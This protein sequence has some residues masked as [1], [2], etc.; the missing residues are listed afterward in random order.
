ML[1]IFKIGMFVLNQE[2]TIWIIA[3]LEKPSLPSPLS[4]VL[5]MGFKVITDAVAFRIFV[6][7][8]ERG[9]YKQ[10]STWHCLEDWQIASLDG[11]QL[12]YM[13]AWKSPRKERSLTGKMEQKHSQ[14]NLPRK[15]VANCWQTQVL[16][17]TEYHEICACVYISRHAHVVTF[18]MANKISVTKA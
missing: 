12:L 3:Y 4:P 14:R 5:S 10:F 1:H 8:E 6:V 15:V 2:G 18:E 16:Q 13:L 17:N 11:C 9:N 7:N